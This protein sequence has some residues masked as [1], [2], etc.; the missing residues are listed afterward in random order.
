MVIDCLKKILKHFSKRQCGK[1]QNKAVRK[2]GVPIG[3]RNGNILN[4]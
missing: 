4:K 2:V 1:T 3:D